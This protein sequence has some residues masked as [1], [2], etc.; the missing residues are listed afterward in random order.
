[1]GLLFRAQNIRGRRKNMLLKAHESRT[2][3]TSSRLQRQ[4][5]QE[6]EKG[7]GSHRRGR[8]HREPR[9]LHCPKSLRRGTTCQP[10]HC[11]PQAFPKWNRLAQTMD[12]FCSLHC[13]APPD[14]F[15]T[16]TQSQSLLSLH[17]YLQLSFP[18]T[19]PH[20]QW[21][22]SSAITHSFS[23]GFHISVHNSAESRMFITLQLSHLLAPC[24]TVSAST[25]AHLSVSHSTKER[26]HREAC[27]Q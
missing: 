26:K 9:E 4:S 6:T 17:F 2:R 7:W 11:L 24:A 12:W 5:L 18:T 14:P 3:N 22:T 16:N 13:C 23:K 20:V 15:V 10:H 1:M 25:P 27:T 21:N 8:Q 19:L